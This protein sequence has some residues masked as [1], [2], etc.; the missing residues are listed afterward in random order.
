MKDKELRRIVYDLLNLLEERSMKQD[1][2][3]EFCKFTDIRVELQKL[4]KEGECLKF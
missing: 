4:A 1:E 2:G 3:F